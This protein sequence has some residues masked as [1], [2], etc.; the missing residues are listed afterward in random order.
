MMPLLLAGP[1]AW[2]LEG[3]HAGK[4]AVDLAEPWQKQ[5]LRSRFRITGANGVQVISVPLENP[6]NRAV[7]SDI[8]ILHQE[9]WKR[10]LVRA[11]QTCYGKSPFYE[12]YDYRLLPVFQKE[13]VFLAD[14]S[15]EL[16][17]LC[18]D[19]L[20]WDIPVEIS[21]SGARYDAEKYEI[22]PALKYRQTFE[23]RNGFQPNLSILDLIFNCGPDAGFL[24]KELNR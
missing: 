19:F 15:L 2:F 21:R 22:L 7:F 14:L 10:D 4:F 11:L 6:G 12:F 13:Q 9:G 1:T 3:L 24:L 17:Q 20:K 5:S 8:R 18:L 23:E 16:L